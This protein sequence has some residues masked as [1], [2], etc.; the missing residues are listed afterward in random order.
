MNEIEKLKKEHRAEIKRILNTIE[1]STVTDIQSVIDAIRNDL[2][3]YSASVNNT[4][5]DFDIDKDVKLYTRLQK[6]QYLVSLFK[7][8]PTLVAFIDDENFEDSDEL[9]VSFNDKEYNP[10]IKGSGYSGVIFYPNGINFDGLD[11]DITLKYIVH[12]LE[13]QE[14]YLTGLYV[15]NQYIELN[16]I[17]TKFK[18]EIML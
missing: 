2:K 17:I 6:A 8:H 1:N 14:D 18:N 10:K 12:I 9:C 3:I 7:G 11:K 5:S 13:F 15:V 4:G 16:D